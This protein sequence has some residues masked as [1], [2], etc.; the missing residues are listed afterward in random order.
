M[1]CEVSKRGIQN[2]KDFWTKSGYSIVKKAQKSDDLHFQND[3]N[4]LITR[5]Y[6][7]SQNIIF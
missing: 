7:Y 3:A 1:G 5:H 2:L 4:F 6:V